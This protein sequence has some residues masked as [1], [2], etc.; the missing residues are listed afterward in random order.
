MRFHHNTQHGKAARKSQNISR[1]GAKAAKFGQVRRY[2]S[3]RSWR[4]FDCTQDM[5]G[6]IN[7]P[8]LRPEPVL[9]DVEGRGGEI[10]E[11]PHP[12]PL[13]GRAREKRNA[14]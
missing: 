11:N 13:P 7:L 9:S 3:L 4:P 2:F 1:K 12:F 14:N 10:S 8:T 5:L 6:A